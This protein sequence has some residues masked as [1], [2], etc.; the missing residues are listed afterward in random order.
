MLPERHWMARQAVLRFPT[1]LQEAHRALSGSRMQERLADGI[2]RRSDGAAILC[3]HN[4][5]ASFDAGSQVSSSQFLDGP[6]ASLELGH[7]A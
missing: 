7:E 6:A 1:R 2:Y 5:S 3:G 4:Q